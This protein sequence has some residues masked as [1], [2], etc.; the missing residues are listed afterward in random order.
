MLIIRKAQADF[1]EQLRLAEFESDALRHLKDCFPEQCERVGEDVVRRIIRYGRGRAERHGFT[2]YRSAFIYLTLMFWIGSGFDEDPV[3]PWAA[4]ILHHPTIGGQL[5]KAAMLQQKALDYLDRAEGV[6]NEHLEG[7]LNLLQ[8]QPI[9][10]L[11]PPCVGDFEDYM[12]ARLLYL[13]P[14]KCK[15][16]GESNLRELIRTGMASADEHGL[17]SERGRGVYIGMMFMLGAHFDS[18]PMFPWVR[19][20]L[21]AGRADDQQAYVHDLYRGAMIYLRSGRR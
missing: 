5:S 11:L 20:I 17:T 9:S 16:V 21:D 7:S 1:F 8:S 2:V 13:H 19:R 3:Y 12:A 6:N 14:Q 18:D 4:H 15:A 10:A